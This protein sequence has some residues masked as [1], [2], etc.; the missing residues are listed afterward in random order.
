M[1]VPRSQST[2]SQIKCD[3]CGKTHPELTRRGATSIRIAASN[4]GWKFAEFD[5][6]P[7]KPEGRAAL[8]LLRR[9]PTAV[10]RRNEAATR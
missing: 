9:V 3:G 4:D 2:F 10:N 6:V 7:R 5:D 1:S 8:G